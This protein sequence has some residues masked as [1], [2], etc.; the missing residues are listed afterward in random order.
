MRYG[1]YFTVTQAWCI[2]KTA[3]FNSELRKLLVEVICSWQVWLVTV[4]LV[5]YI[6]LVNYV[7]RVYRRRDRP[8]PKQTLV[9]PSSK[10]ENPAASA[11]AASGVS[12]D[13]DELELEEEAPPS[14][15]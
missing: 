12:T 6:F 11:P 3:M 7:A 14:K 13:S 1:R 10:P 2:L 15:K 5:L 8:A 9:I 4:V